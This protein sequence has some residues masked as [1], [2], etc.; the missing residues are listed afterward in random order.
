MSF[1]V[2]ARYIAK[3]GYFVRTIE[4]IKGDDIHWRDQVGTG[5]CSLDSFA[6]WAGELSPDSPPPPKSQPRAKPITQS[7]RDAIQ[8][9]LLGIRQFRKAA[10]GIRITT[11]DSMTESLIALLQGR[12]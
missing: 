7:V 11:P 8:N 6:R 4:Q 10:E 5:R 1:F 12:M 9:E 3:G 2:G